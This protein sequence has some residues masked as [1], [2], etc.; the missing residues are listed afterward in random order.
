MSIEDVIREEVRNSAERCREAEDSLREALKE[1]YLPPW[2][3]QGLVRK[4]ERLACAARNILRYYSVQDEELTV[5]PLAPN[6]VRISL[7]V[8]VCPR[9]E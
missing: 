7:G 5:N 3:D 8:G 6:Q 1:W 2:S 9:S 4:G